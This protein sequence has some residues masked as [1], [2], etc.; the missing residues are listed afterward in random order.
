M[1]KDR[2]SAKEFVEVVY[3]GKLLHFMEKVP[4]RFLME[5]GAHVHR[6]KLFEEWR[7]AYHL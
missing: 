5:V 3:N 4:Q 7:Q 6:S 2:R 1:P